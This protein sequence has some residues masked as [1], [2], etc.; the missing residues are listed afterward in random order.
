MNKKEVVSFRVTVPKGSKNIIYKERVKA[1]GTVEEVRVR[2]YRGQQLAL[3]VVPYVNHKGRKHE[4]LLTFAG[5]TNGYLCGDDDYFVYPVVVPV[6]DND[7]VSVMV[8]NTDAAN[9]YTL[10]VD[11]VV[12][13]YAGKNRIIGGVHHG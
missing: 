5:N 3:Q 4:Q 6:E 10:S 11:V 2:F 13:Y 1:D 8:T 7:Y 12:D 9:D